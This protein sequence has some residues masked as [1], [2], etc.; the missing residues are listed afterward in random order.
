MRYLLYA[1]DFLLRAARDLV[2]PGNRNREVWVTEI[3]GLQPLYM[4]PCRILTLAK[5]LRRRNVEN[6]ADVR[7]VP[8]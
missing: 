2:K 1:G 4:Q 5:S 8:L 3:T 6:K 7:M